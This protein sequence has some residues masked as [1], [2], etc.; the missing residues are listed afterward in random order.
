MTNPPET[1][2]ETREVVRIPELETLDRQALRDAA[3]AHGLDLVVLFGSTA[4]GR[5]RPQS[6]L[7]VAVRFAPPRPTPPTLDEE[8]DVEGALLQLLKPPCELDLVLLNGASPLLQWNVARYGIPLFSTS[9]DTWNTFRIRA[10]RIY[11]DTAKFRRRQWEVLLQRL[12]RDTT[13]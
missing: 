2:D 12:G 5:R 8:V 11:E 1:M 3:L 9:A 4:R 7:D 10:S 6:D 13:E